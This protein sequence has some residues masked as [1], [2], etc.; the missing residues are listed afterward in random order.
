MGK[1]SRKQAVQQ[2]TFGRMLKALRADHVAGDRTLARAALD[3]LA[4]ART[5][6][7][8]PEQVAVVLDSL[9]DFADAHEIVKGAHAPFESTLLDFGDGLTDDT[10]VLLGV[11]LFGEG[12]GAFLSWHPRYRAMGADM[13]F[14]LNLADHFAETHE[15]MSLSR[16]EF[17]TKFPSSETY[18][19]FHKRWDTYVGGVAWKSSNWAREVAPYAALALLESANVELVDSP[20]QYQRGHV[21]FGTPKYDIYIR[22]GRRAP[23]VAGGGEASYSHRFEVRGN[24]AHHFELTAAGTPNR[25]FEK[26]ATEKPDKVVQVGGQP[27]IR[28]WRPPFV[29]G[30]EDKPLVPKIRHL[31]KAT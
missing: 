27:C 6:T 25:L 19:T 31:A 3:A 12:D 20:Q 7:I 1:K 22:Q 9:V 18:D 21:A 16:E 28:I 26:W 13:V 4:N 11:L 29:K 23:G 2:T 14:I 15:L 5:I 10:D 24:F 8:A 30:P 17:T